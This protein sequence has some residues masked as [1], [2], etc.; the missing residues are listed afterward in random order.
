[1]IRYQFPVFES[2]TDQIPVHIPSKWLLEIP[3]L[4]MIELTLTGSAK[5]TITSGRNLIA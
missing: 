2:E 4:A 1:L 3:T 5:V